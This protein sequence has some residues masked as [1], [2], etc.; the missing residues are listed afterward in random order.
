MCEM[1]ARFEEERLR[2]IA[3]IQKKGAEN[4][5]RVAPRS[6]L[7]DFVNP[8]QVRQDIAQD[9]T[10]QG[11]GV[12]AGKIY[13]PSTF[14]GSPR[15]MRTQYYNSMGLVARKG[16]P[17]FF[18]TFTACGQWDELR[19]STRHGTKCD[20]ATCCRIFDIKLQELLRDIRSGALF[21]PQ[22]Y[23]VHVIEM[24]MRGLPHAHIA[25]RMEDG[26]P[27]QGIDIDKVIRADIPAPDEANGRELVL[28]HMI[29]GPCGTN[30]H[31]DVKCWDRDKKRCSKFFPKPACDT[32][33]M[34]GALCITNGITIT[35][36]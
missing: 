19:Q 7:Q 17:T 35:K 20:P 14:T 21:G 2:Y 11:E 9:E 34:K 36:L 30:Y 32:T 29:H 1:F 3:R 12:T 24:Q 22:A 27:T 4:Q 28:K 25:S 8:Q 10:I 5:T 15:Y 26:G 18:L 6:E 16:K 31:T 23:I 33:Y 13:L